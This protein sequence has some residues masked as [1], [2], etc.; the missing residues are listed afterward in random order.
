MVAPRRISGS[1][2]LDCSMFEPAAV[3]AAGLIRSAN[4]FCVYDS[5]ATWA[6]AGAGVRLARTRFGMGAHSPKEHSPTYTARLVESDHSQHD[7]RW[8]RILRRTRLAV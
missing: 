8:E 4:Y 6:A 3:V 7:I 2:A 5:L 1:V